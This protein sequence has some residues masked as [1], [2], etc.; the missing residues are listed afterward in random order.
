VTRSSI[1]AMTYA[2]FKTATGRTPR[3]HLQSAAKPNARG[4]QWRATNDG[5][6]K[7]GAG[8]RP[9]THQRLAARSDGPDVFPNRHAEDRRR[10]IER[11]DAIEGRIRGIVHA[12]HTRVDGHA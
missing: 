7:R 2:P 11:N 1:V 8:H 10:L 4:C 6:R 3:S 12:Q 9:I 5:S